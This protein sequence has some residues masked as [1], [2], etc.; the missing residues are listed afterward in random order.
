MDTWTKY[1]ITSVYWVC[2]TYLIFSTWTYNILTLFLPI[3]SFLLFIKWIQLNIR[4][5]RLLNKK[6]EN[7]IQ[8]KDNDSFPIFK[9]LLWILIIGF[10]LIKFTQYQS[11][12]RFR[13]SMYDW[14][15][16]ILYIWLPFFTISSIL[17]IIWTLKSKKFSKI[18]FIFTLIIF[19]ISTFKLLE[20]FIYSIKDRTSGI[21]NITISNEDKYWVFQNMIKTWNWTCEYSES[22]KYDEIKNFIYSSDWKS[23]AFVGQK[24]NKAYVIKDWIESYAGKT[25]YNISYQYSPNWK[26]FSY[27][28]KEGKKWILVIDWTEI[29]KYDSISN[30]TYSSDW[31]SFYYTAKKNW[32]SFIVNDWI[33]SD[34]YESIFFPTYSSDW[35]SFYY[36]AK[37][38]WKSF[39]VKDWVESK[40]YDS[41]RSS[42]YSP[43]WKDFYYIAKQNWKSFIVK[44]W[45]EWKKYD[46]IIDF[47]YSS[48]WKKLAFKI[49]KDWKSFIVKDWV[50]SKKYDDIYDYKYSS[51]WKNFAFKAKKDWKYII[52]KD[53][54]ES[55]KYDR[56]S[57][58]T[59]SPDWKSFAFKALEININAGSRTEREIIVKDWI[60]KKYDNIFSYSY[61][62]D[63][64]VFTVKAKKYWKY[65]IIE[66]WVEINKY[67]SRTI[68][69]KSPDWKNNI[70]MKYKNKKL[71]V[72][73]NWIK[74][75]HDISNKLQSFTFSPD[76]KSF[77]YRIRKNLNKYFVNKDW[78]NSN[79]YD[80]VG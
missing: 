54:V 74:N 28:T 57:G 10:I 16:E 4:S 40:K 49:K 7:N 23:F 27:K 67:D 15:Y 29:D 26:S 50:E 1:I 79:I 63:W 60:K 11:S 38:Y 3:S 22:N 17:I 20:S 32:K 77:V 43:N 65:L 70:I 64:K 8:V 19:I 34:D 24:G 45:I 78:V 44:N 68:F 37:K 80:Y 6:G 73:I 71:E 21:K 76:W 61:S 69:E 62:P 13:S 39:I 41:I 59:F 14:V 53:W 75:I 66:N 46:N 12:L 25:I 30:L 2:I 9:I 58:F 33:E 42:T 51:D 35:K 72:E 47:E 55:K 36:V 18:L 52:V 31:R 5:K 48:D 56:I